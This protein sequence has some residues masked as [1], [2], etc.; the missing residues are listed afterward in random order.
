MKCDKCGNSFLVKNIKQFGVLCY[1]CFSLVLEKMEIFREAW[2]D[3]LEPKVKADIV[4]FLSKNTDLQV[5]DYIEKSD[6]DEKFIS[7]CVTSMLAY[8]ILPESIRE[9]LHAYSKR[10]LG[11]D[12]GDY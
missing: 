11:I 12:F 4:S 9:R 5:E 7:N 1:N 3:E 8:E 2:L 6:F 10:Q